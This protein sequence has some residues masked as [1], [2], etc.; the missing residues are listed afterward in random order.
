[1]V[2][3]KLFIGT[4]TPRL[5]LDLRDNPLSPTS[6]FFSTTWL[7]LASPYFGSESDIEF[8]RI[9]FRADY[10]VPLWAGVSCYF[11]FRTG[12][13]Q[14]EAT[15]IPLI[16]Q[17]ALGGIGSLRGYQEQELNNQ[18][19]SI[20]GNLSYVNYRTQLDLPFSGPLKFGI[21]L[22]AA[23]L[24][25]DGFSFV[26]LVKLGTGLGFHYQTPVGPVNLDWGFKVDPAPAEDPYVIHFSVGII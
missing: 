3:I 19:T 12:I 25:Q 15:S 11:S 9:Q 23:N 6:G 4:I 26:R 24:I 20:I 21:F 8:Y 22:D 1:M 7:D 13:E 18:A 17:F 10:H 14:N 2:T 5:S 16:K